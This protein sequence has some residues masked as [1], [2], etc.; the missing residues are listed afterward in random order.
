MR[1]G[2]NQAFHI[3]STFA[4]LAALHY[5]DATG[6]GQMIDIAL[7]EGLFTLLGSHVVDYDQLGIVQGYYQGREAALRMSRRLAVTPT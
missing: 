5:R 1:G 2:G 7:Y 6:R 4:V 3:G